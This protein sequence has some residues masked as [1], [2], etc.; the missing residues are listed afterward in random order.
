MQCRCP[1]VVFVTIIETVVADDFADRKSAVALAIDFKFFLKKGIDLHFCTMLDVDVLAAVA[2]ITFDMHIFGKFNLLF[3]D[4]R[5]ADVSKTQCS[6]LLYAGFC[7]IR[8]V[9]NES[10]SA[11]CAVRILLRI[12][13]LLEVFYEFVWSDDV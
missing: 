9:W 5:V 1:Y 12:E 13:S 6:E 3:Y 8:I 11:E 4:D 10:D 7:C 2:D